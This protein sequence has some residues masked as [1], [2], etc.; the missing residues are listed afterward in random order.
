MRATQPRRS[1]YLPQDR[2]TADLVLP[3]KLAG[4]LASG[5]PVLAQADEGTEF[6]NLLNGVAIVV[7]TGD[8]DALARA[9]AD[10]SKGNLSVDGYSEVALFF[11]RERSLPMFRELV[12]ARPRLVMTKFWV[13][14]AAGAVLY[15]IDKT[16]AAFPRS[17]RARVGT[18]TD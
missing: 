10:A 6:H 9:I 1:P 5:R 8:E 2:N 4:A 7:P 13:S 3:S 16:L 15:A 17:K 12:C 14:V 11:A 18:D